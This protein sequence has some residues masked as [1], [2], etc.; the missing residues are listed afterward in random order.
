MVDEDLSS[1]EFQ[2]ENYYGV[3]DKLDEFAALCR[4]RS[5]AKIVPFKLYAYQRKL[6]EILEEHQTVLVL[7]DRQIGITEVL[8][9]FLFKGMLQNS[10]Y[11]GALLSINQDKSSDVSQR[12]KLMASAFKDLVWTSDSFKRKAIEN[13]GSVEFL[14]STDNAAR[15]LPSVLSLIYDECGFV[16]NFS[17]LYGAGTSAQEM[18]DDGDRTTVLNTT[19]PPGG[20]L[21]EFWGMLDS[22]NGNVSA[23]EYV[24]LAR[25]A[26]TNCGHP[27]MMF[28]VDEDGA[29]KVILSHK[30]HPKYGKDPDYLKNVQKRRKIPWVIVQREHNLGIEIAGNALFSSDA[31]KSQ[32]IGA[33]SEPVAD[34]LYL[35]CVDP[36]FGGSDNWCTQVWDCTTD[37]KSLVAEYAESDRSV[38]YSKNKTLDLID[39]YK[40][41]L[42]AVESNSGGMVIVEDLIKDRKSKR[43]EV[44]KTTRTSKRVNTDRCAYY[45]DQGMVAYPPDWKGV[46]EM[47]KFSSSER[48]ATG[49]EKDDRIMS[50]AAGFA[51]IDEVKIVSGSQTTALK[52]GSS[53]D[54]FRY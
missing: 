27:G 20:E 48:E 9:L 36:N 51:W 5:G 52:Y 18:V 17:E 41:S 24:K 33:W 43:I 21:S 35:V 6:F 30:V 22:S 54:R 3:P 53:K 38:D 14:P 26:K 44:T 39:R 19:V 32:A 16:Q 31:I 2:I 15:G 10:A 47:R 23:Y 25:D 45:L 8:A 49:G 40:A 4:I 50:W 11:L 1:E 42:I 37:V 12:L 13:C 29:A 28:W 34:H 7:K 46:Q